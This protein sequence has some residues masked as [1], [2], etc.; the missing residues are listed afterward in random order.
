MDTAHVLRCGTYVAPLCE[1]VQQSASYRKTAISCCKTNVLACNAVHLVHF[2][3]QSMMLLSQ[4]LT[5]TARCID[6][7]MHEDCTVH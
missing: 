6:N 3:A 7:D 2:A 5:K 1:C 4:Q